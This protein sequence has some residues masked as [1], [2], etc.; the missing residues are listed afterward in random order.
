MNKLKR[1]RLEAEHRQNKKTIDQMNAH[2][3]IL[4]KRNYDIRQELE[5]DKTN[6]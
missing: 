2:M 3:K 5:K 6:G 1:G 4:K